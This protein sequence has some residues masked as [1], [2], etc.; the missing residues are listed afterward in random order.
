MVGETGDKKSPTLKRVCQPLYA[1]Q[2]VLYTRYQQALAD[3]ER[4]LEQYTV[5][6]R[7]WHQSLRRSKTRRP[8]LPM[9]QKPRRPLLRQ[10]LTTDTA[11]EAVP[12]LLRDNPRGLLIVRD[13]LT[14]W[15]RSLNQYKGG[16]GDDRQLY[17]SAWS[18]TFSLANRK[19]QEE[20]TIV[21]HPFLTVMGGSPP[22]VLGE[23][24]D[25]EGREDGFVQRLLFAYPHP[26]EETWSAATVPPRV[27]AA[28]TKAIH[29]LL[30]LAPVKDAHGHLWPKVLRFTEEA[31]AMWVRFCTA[32]D[33]ERRAPN[34]PAYLRGAWNKM[35][36]YGARLALILH[37]LRVVCGEAD[38]EAVDAI[39]LAGAWALIEYFKSHARRVYRQLQHDRS[40]QL[41]E[42]AERWIRAH[43]GRCTPRDLQRANVA[44]IKRASEAAKLLRDLADR[45][46]GQITLSKSSKKVTVFELAL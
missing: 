6:L 13:E 12:D 21:A 24:T 23:L 36:A 15:V 29:D 35:P 20:P 34:F 9:P 19:G 44:G 8:R 41:A 25:A 14:G 40:H 5:Q 7:L 32:H 28:W 46:R 27:D 16:R 17:L 18:G 31:Q 11:R 45:G 42:A 10:L 4:A 22:S 33:V 26:V 1:R 2:E 3:Y 39:S 38:D 43:G 37:E 30:R